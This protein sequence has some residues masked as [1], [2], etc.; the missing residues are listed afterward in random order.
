MA[1]PPN[2]NNDDSLDALKKRLDRWGAPGS[3]EKRSTLGASES[4]NTVPAWRSGIENY[5]ALEEAQP[6]GNALP[7]ARKVLFA[8]ILFF[9]VTVAAGLFFAFSGKNVFSPDQVTI[10]ATGPVTIGG[11]EELVLQVAIANKNNL[12]LETADFSVEFPPGTRDPEDTGKELR[13]S[14]RDLIGTIKAGEVVTK[15]IRA[16]VF[17]EENSEQKIR[18]SLEYRTPDSA[19][20]FVAEKEYEITISSSPVDLSATLPEEILSGQEVPLDIT[21]ISQSESDVKKV[22][23]GAQYPPGFIF[24]RSEPAPTRGT[25]TWDIGDLPPGGKTTIHVVGVVEG[26][27]SEI[28]SFKVSA[29]LG[30]DKNPEVISTIYSSL[31]KSLTIERPQLGLMLALA[32]SEESQL[33]RA[34]GEEIHGELSWKNNLAERV[35]NVEVHAKF[36]GASFDKSSVTSDNRGFY[37]SSVPEILWD[38]NTTPALEV[39]D[40]GEEGQF[41]FGFEGLNAFKTPSLK[42]RQVDLELTISGTRLSE[43]KPPVRVETK[44]VRKVLFPAEVQLVARSLYSVGPFKNTGPLPPAVE[45]KTTYTVVWSLAGTGSDVSNAVVEATLPVYSAWAGLTSP[46]TEKISFNPATQKVTWNVGALKAGTGSVS[47]AREVSFQV[48]LT[49]SLVQA[50]AT[51]PLTSDVTFL[52]DDQFTKTKVTAATGAVS[53]DIETDP[54]YSSDKARVVKT[55]AK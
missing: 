6:R 43:G 12:E 33:V 27:D 21:V 44:I 20:I 38:K 22:L 28:K 4:R 8:A 48:A 37:Q 46:G 26:Q 23:V 42:N 11:G 9:G 36:T 10:S 32:G 17:G 1:L 55:P 50:G 29:G 2:S 16:V 49:P 34:G 54:V 15:T 5:A 53:T 14:P 31:F 51:L 18:L 41:S 24:K 39:L 30:D 7:L 45:Q 52:S 25:N 47:S 19:A 3:T 13:R 35:Q 40:P